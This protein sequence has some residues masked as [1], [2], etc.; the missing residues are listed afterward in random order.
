LK[1]LVLFQKDQKLLII[2]K[3]PLLDVEVGIQMLK[4][5]FS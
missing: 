2:M 4:E 3:R 5:A 1:S